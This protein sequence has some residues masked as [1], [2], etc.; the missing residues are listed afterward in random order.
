MLAPLYDVI[1]SGW[2]LLLTLP[3]L[4]LIAARETV[5]RPSATLG[6][7]ALLAMLMAYPMLQASIRH[8]FHLEFVWVLAVL[9][10]PATWIDKARL[11]VTPAA[12]WRL[13]AAVALGLAI[14]TAGVYAIALVWQQHALRGA[15][16]TLLALPREPIDA[17]PA[18]TEDGGLRFALDV[19]PDR[20]AITQAAPDSMTTEIVTMGLQWDVRAEVDRLLLTIRDCPRGRYAVQAAYAKTPLAW[21]FF[22]NTL[23]LTLD[24][25]EGVTTV[26]MPAFYRPTQ[27][28]ETLALIPAEGQSLSSCQLVLERVTAPSKLPLLMTVVLP[29][30]WRNDRLARGFGA[31]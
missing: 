30:D 4:A 8:L 14:L 12:V 23:D 6:T 25:A 29:M 21:Q 24:G 7:V 20:I 16:E 2:I 26:L 15:F 28:L 10:L 22:D 13:F 5:L 18:P 19:P 27:H 1:G 9:A 31:F 11:R 17:S 3:G